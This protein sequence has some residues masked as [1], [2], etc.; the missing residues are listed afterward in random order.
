MNKTNF[1]PSNHL[2]CTSI[3]RPQ[4]NFIEVSFSEVVCVY[5]AT[6]SSQPFRLRIL[7]AVLFAPCLIPV[8]ILNAD[9]RHPK[10]STR[11]RILPRGRRRLGRKMIKLLHIAF[12]SST[13]LF[14]ILWGD[15]SVRFETST[16]HLDSHPSTTTTE[17]T[18]RR[19]ENR[20]SGATKTAQYSTAAG[21]E[22]NRASGASKSKPCSEASIRVN[23]VKALS[24]PQFT[25]YHLACS[26]STQ[27]PTFTRRHPIHELIDRSQTVWRSKLAIQ[28][29]KLLD[30]TNEYRRRYSREPPLG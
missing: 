5:H 30:A 4:P 1:N 29:I 12:L 19:K 10:P 6:R 16:T 25:F 9:H 7:T 8:L 21:R 22:D 28:S 13:F 26:K 23:V 2:L 20:A 18:T 24:V 15:H 27:N 11:I 3:H 17:A 14:F